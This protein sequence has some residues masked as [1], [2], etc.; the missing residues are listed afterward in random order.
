M[1]PNVSKHIRMYPKMYDM[2]IVFI[3]VKRKILARFQ[4]PKFM[5]KW[6]LFKISLK[7]K[8]T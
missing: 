1:Y 6:T 4:R 5:G 8:E 2:I 7:V 3:T